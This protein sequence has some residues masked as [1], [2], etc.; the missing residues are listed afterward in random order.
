MRRELK[1]R[2]IKDLKVVYSSEAPIKP[3]QVESDYLEDGVKK[4]RGTTASIAFVP[5]V[6]GLIIASEVIKDLVAKA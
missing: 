4:R 2:G 6:A 3:E 5:S 1:N